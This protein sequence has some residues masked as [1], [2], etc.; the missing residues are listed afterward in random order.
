MNFAE[1]NGLQLLAKPFR[2]ADFLRTIDQA[3]DSG[4][5]GQQSAA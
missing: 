5:V 1:E 2:L 4:K 3:L